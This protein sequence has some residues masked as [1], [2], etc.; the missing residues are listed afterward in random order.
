MKLNLK[1]R[2]I[3]VFLLLTVGCSTV[4]NKEEDLQFKNFIHPKKVETATVGD[5]RNFLVFKKKI[6][7]ES[8]KKSNILKVDKVY[9]Y[10]R[11]EDS[12]TFTV[13]GSNGNIYIATAHLGEYLEL[14]GNTVIL[15]KPVPLRCIGLFELKND[16]IKVKRWE[17][18]PFKEWTENDVGYIKNDTVVYTE[19]YI[20]KKYEYK[21]KWLAKTHK[22]NFRFGY[23]PTLIANF[24][25]YGHIGEY[26]VSG[27]FP[28]Q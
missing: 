28:V 20:A 10:N 18:T 21:K 11:S 6:E 19:T 12:F 7:E 2:I 14:N 13:F 9:M 25:E 17:K 15:K 22:T 27:S 3:I 26:E 8:L 4:K 16:V 1:N 24:Y 23:Q 5:Y